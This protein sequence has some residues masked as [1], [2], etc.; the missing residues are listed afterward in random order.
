MVS[1]GVGYTGTSRGLGFNT[2]LASECYQSSCTI[3]A[4]YFNLCKRGEVY[5]RQGLGFVGG[6]VTKQEELHI[7]FGLP[8]RKGDG[9]YV[10]KSLTG[11][12]TALNE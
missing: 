7:L 4:R 1:E 3:T 6:V 8:S 10:N 2:K 11:I 12:P 5:R 9:L